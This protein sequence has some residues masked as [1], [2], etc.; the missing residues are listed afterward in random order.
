MT[1]TNPSTYE[2]RDVIKAGA[3]ATAALAVGNAFAQEKQAEPA[4]PKP[5][6]PPIKV[7]LLGCGGRGT[8]AA[9]DALQADSGVVIHAIG[10]IL[11]IA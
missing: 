1:E 3:M 6:L 11:A 10:D 2:R 8:G 7:G 5:K 4:Q 9:F